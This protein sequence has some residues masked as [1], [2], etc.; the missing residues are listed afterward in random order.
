MERICVYCGSSPGAQ[1]E[2]G[3][4][5]QALGRLLAQRGLGLV[6]GGAH[7]GIMGRVADCGQ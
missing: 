4:A 7:V 5:A 6:Y 1:A 3:E 2:F